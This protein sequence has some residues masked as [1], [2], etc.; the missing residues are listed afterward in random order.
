VNFFDSY[1]ESLQSYKDIDDFVKRT[2]N[3]ASTKILSLSGLPLQGDKS[4]VCGHWCI[5][6]VEILASGLTFSDFI[7]IFKDNSGY[8]GVY[9]DFIK[10]Y[11]I[12]EFCKAEGCNVNH[13]KPKKNLQ[14]CICKYLSCC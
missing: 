5:V 4:D 7:D 6:F 1:G 3:N 12:R 2:C 9:D 13:L 8:A 11:V 14:K 10:N